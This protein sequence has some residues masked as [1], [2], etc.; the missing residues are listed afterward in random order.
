MNGTLTTGE[1][2]TRF[3]PFLT[4]AFFG[5]VKP[6]QGLRNRTGKA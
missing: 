1:T 3:T 5:A 6:R 4:V 2:F